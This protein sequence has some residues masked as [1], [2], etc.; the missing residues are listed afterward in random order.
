MKDYFKKSEFLVQINRGD[1]KAFLQMYDF[2]AIQLLRHLSYRLNSRETAED[3][4][5]QVF[6]KVWQYLMGG[7]NKIDNLNAFLYRIA[8]NL[9]SD[10]YR[11]S[12]RK[13]ISLD[14]DPSHDLERK[15]A[16]EPS[17]SEE[18]DQGSAVS[19]VKKSLARLTE[20]QQKLIIWRYFDDLSISEIAEVSGKS[21]NAVY[22]GLHRALKDLKKLLA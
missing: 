16:V 12:E 11:K 8:D 3:M 7:E 20:D 2:Y 6:Y 9:L 4:T 15:L 5:Q 21:S 19:Q 1:E 22:V 17:Y 13:N 14:D 10:Y 18:I